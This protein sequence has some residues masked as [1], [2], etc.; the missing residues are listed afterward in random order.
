MLHCIVWYQL[1]DV[2]H[3]LAAIIFSAM[4]RPND[5]G[6]SETSLT[7]Y[8]TKRRNISE[9]SYLHTRRSENLKFKGTDNE[10][11]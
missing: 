2:S 10:I 11:L 5:G 1:T 3:V 6:T 8:Q 7:F 9:D 4:F